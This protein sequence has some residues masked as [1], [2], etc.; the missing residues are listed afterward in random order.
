MHAT[1]HMYDKHTHMH[2]TCD[3]YIK[4]TLR[5]LEWRQ[6]LLSSTQTMHVTHIHTSHVTH[7]H[8]SH[9][10]DIN[11]PCLSYA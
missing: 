6:A 3:T 10:K 5:S 2:E 8:T 1:C 4:H 9:V 7:I 11:E